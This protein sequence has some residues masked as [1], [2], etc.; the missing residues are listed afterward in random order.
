L[1]GEHDFAAFCRRREGASTVRGL[2]EYRWHRDDAGIVVATVRADAFCHS[3]VRAL[4]GA[5]LPVGEH[6]R[7]VEWP[8]GVLRQGVRDPAVTVA[9]AHGLCLEQVGYPD[10]AGLA[11][12]AEAARAYRGRTP[13][14]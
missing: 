7:G 5:L 10:E 13:H 1:L 6:R 2:L 8:A 3:M 12:R 4:V 11:A 9:P 14:A